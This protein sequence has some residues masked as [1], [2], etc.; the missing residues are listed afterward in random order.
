MKNYTQIREGV[1]ESVRSEPQRPIDETRIREIVRDRACQLDH[2]A[3]D[4]RR[5]RATDEVRHRED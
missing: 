3:S 4:N 2:G 5:D 1:Y